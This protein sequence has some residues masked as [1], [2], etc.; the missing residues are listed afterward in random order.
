MT[1]RSYTSPNVATNRERA[2]TTTPLTP[3]VAA[4]ATGLPTVDT[5]TGELFEDA[6]PKPVITLSAQLSYR[7]RSLTVTASG[8]TLSAFYEAVDARADCLFTISTGARDDKQR[9]TVIEASHMT[10]DSFC[11]MLDKK[12]GVPS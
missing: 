5:Q 11:D 6:P 9:F 8:M 12:F 4:A 1:I 3:A 2:D 10:L 7:G